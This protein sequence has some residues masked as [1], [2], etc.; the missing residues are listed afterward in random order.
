MVKQ[1]GKLSL[2]VHDVPEA[3][4]TKVA[5]LK[6]ASMGLGIDKLTAEQIVYLAS[7]GEGT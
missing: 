2:D 6:L 4:E 7:S 5:K 1:K 3:I